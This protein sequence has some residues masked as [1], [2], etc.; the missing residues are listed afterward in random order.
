MSIICF[1]NNGNTTAFDADGQQIGEFQEGW[2]RTYLAFLRNERGL[3]FKEVEAITFKMPDGSEYKY[4]AEN[5][6]WVSV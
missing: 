1:F 3:T 2:L 5:D 6:N 4:I